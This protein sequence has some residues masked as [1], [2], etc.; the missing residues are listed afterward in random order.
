MDRS[1]LLATIAIAGIALL[2]TW[3]LT[4]RIAGPIEELRGAAQD[5]ARGNLARRVDNRGSDEI[6]ELSRSFNAMA[7]ALEEQ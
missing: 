1:L 3:T 5:L 2:A 7:A 4:G 6:A